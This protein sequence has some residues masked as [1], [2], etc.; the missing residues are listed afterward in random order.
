MGSQ[1]TSMGSRCCGEVGS[2]FDSLCTI[3]KEVFSPDSMWEAKV[4]HFVTSL[5]GMTV[6]NAEL[7]S[8]KSSYGRIVLL[9]QVGQ[10]SVDS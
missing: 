3:A 2:Y 5:F 4:N 7:K 8:M 10:G 1:H 6:L 9:F